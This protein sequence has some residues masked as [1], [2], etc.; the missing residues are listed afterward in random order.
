MVASSAC[1]RR[2]WSCRPGRK[3][4]L[5]G[6]NCLT[7][8]DLLCVIPSGVMPADAPLTSSMGPAAARPAT[9]AGI[10]LTERPRTI[11]RCLSLM[12]LHEQMIMEPS[13]ASELTDAARGLQTSWLCSTLGDSRH[14]SSQ[15]DLS[16]DR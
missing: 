14:S 13:S 7:L 3:D 8:F 15:L 10:D 4:A 1:R 9:Q 2:P 5:H 12:T 6:V 11:L 16:S